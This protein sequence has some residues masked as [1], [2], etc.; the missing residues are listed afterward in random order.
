M[1]LQGRAQDYYS[2]C[3]TPKPTP[4]FF[5]DIVEKGKYKKEQFLSKCFKYF[6]LYHGPFNCP[7]DI[8][9]T[10]TNINELIGTVKEK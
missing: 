1:Q 10:K 2:S 6:Q 7:G 9:L 4:E 5:K 8:Y 3:I